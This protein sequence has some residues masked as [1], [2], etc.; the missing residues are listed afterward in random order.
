MEDVAFATATDHERAGTGYRFESARGSLQF[1]VDVEAQLPA[2]GG[3]GDVG[4]DVLGQRGGAAV[5]APFFFGALDVADGG[6][7][8][9]VRG[10]LVAD[11]RPALLGDDL[12]PFDGFPRPHPGL[13]REFFG[14]V[15]VVGVGDRHLFAFFAVE[16]ERR[17]E[18]PLVEPFRAFDRTVVFAEE[19][20]GDFAFAGVEG[21]G[22]DG[23]PRRGL[24]AGAGIGD[25]FAF[26][27]GAVVDAHLVDQTLEA[28][29]RV[30][31]VAADHQVAFAPGGA[32]GVSFAGGELAVDVEAHPAAVVG[33]GEV[34]PDVG[35]EGFAPL[36]A[37]VFAF[38]AFGEEGF[39]L[40]GF[41]KADRELVAFVAVGVLVDDRLA[42]EG[43]RPHP[44]LDRQLFGDPQVFGIGDGDAA[45][46]FAVEVQRRAEAAVVEPFGAAF[47][48]AVVFVA[49]DVFGDFA[50]AGVEGVGGDGSA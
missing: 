26:A 9:T 33:E 40:A 49:G 44:G 28:L 13:K 27:Q 10:Q 39:G 11:A 17:A 41:I 43:A 32:F 34:G 21:V 29:R 1:S 16:G 37:V 4:P 5:D 6:V 23:R 36:D 38:I 14:E 35:F 18:A 24:Q 47:D 20:L 7:V 42:R 48:R 8:V 15:Q 19:V 12:A 46:F 22:G 2:V 3:V 45:F 30:V 50:F 25:D 31:R